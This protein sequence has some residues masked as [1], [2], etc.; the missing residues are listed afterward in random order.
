VESLKLRLE[1]LD[2]GGVFFDG[3]GAWYESLE[4]VLKKVAETENKDCM[5]DLSELY[6]NGI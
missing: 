1:D 2:S 3:L 5:D 6:L 4:K